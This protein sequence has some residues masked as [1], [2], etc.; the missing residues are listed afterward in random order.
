MSAVSGSNAPVFKSSTSTAPKA[1]VFSVLS[2][3]AESRRN[4]SRERASCFVSGNV[5]GNQEVLR[6]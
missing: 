4:R 5:A 1:D 3:T 2:G 6:T